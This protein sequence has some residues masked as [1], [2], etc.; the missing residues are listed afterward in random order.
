[1]PLLNKKPIGRREV[2]PN[3]KLTDKVYY[4]EA[5]NEIFTTYDEFFERMIQLNSTLFSCEYTGKTG[6]T[7]FEALDSEKQAMVSL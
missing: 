3:V 2:P 6:L 7:Y 5:S 4:L 1:M